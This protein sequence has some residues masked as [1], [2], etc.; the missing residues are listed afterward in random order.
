MFQ[1]F[2][3]NSVNLQSLA[4]MAIAIVGSGAHVQAKTTDQERVRLGKD[5]TCV[6]SEKAGT[7]S[8]VAEFTGKWIGVPDTVKFDPESR[9]YPSPYADE[10][11]LFKI[12]GA[13]MKEY[14][15]HLTPGQ[16]ALLKKYP[17]TYQ[18]HVY[19]SHR[20]FGYE[21]WRCERTL[22]N[23]KVAEI[24][25]DGMGV[26]GIRGGIVFPIP[27]NGI[28]MF[29][30]ITTPLRVMEEEAIYDNNVIYSNG[31]RTKGRVYYRIYSINNDPKEPKK[32]GKVAMANVKVL[33]PEREKGNIFVSM[34]SENFKT[35]PRVAWQY[36]AGTRRVRQMPTFGFDMP[37]PAAGG[38]A[39]IDDDRLFNGSPERY[40]WKLVGKREIYIPYNNYQLDSPD[41]DYKTLYPAK[42]H[43]PKYWRYELHRVWV[44]EATLKKGYRHLYAKR[45][46]YVDEDSHTMVQVENYD[47]R[48]EL[49]RVGILSPLYIYDAKAFESRTFLSYDLNSG[50]YLVDRIVNEQKERPLYNR[51]NFKPSVFTPGGLRSQGR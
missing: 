44:L 38:T 20:D 45:R 29:W 3:K 23:T 12:T 27:E 46:F 25:D 14:E 36:N 10:K 42:H 51:S 5:L 35:K 6:G 17:K 47:A 19:P 41:L 43:N 9:V 15:K 1:L 37:N 18:L 4:L 2:V 39:T 26:N 48:G 21:K 22:E 31:R 11:P 8:G 49:W 32:M 7:E 24:V 40:D 50:A 13:N 30:N 28:E 16:M 34:D 33:L